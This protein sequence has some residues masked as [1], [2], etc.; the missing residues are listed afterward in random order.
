MMTS[1]YSKSSNFLVLN[2]LLEKFNEVTLYV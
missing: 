1:T 2:P